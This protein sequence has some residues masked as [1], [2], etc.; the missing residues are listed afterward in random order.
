MAYLFVACFEGK[1]VSLQASPPWGPPIRKAIAFADQHC[2]VDRFI[3]DLGG[4]WPPL[5]GLA[6]VVEELGEFAEAVA[7][8][9]S[10]AQGEE[11]TDLFT[12]VSAITNQ[13]CAW[14]SP[15]QVE[16]LSAQDADLSQ[17]VQAC[18]LLGR[19]VNQFEGIK[20]PKP[21]EQVYDIRLV[22]ARICA[23][24]ERLVRELGGH[25]P[26]MVLDSLKSK[27]VRDVDRFAVSF[28][29]TTAKSLDVL[30]L[31]KSKALVDWAVDAR[32]WGEPSADELHHSGTG[33]TVPLHH[34]ER[35][36]RI[37][38]WLPL[39]A[40]VGMTT[41]SATHEE[42]LRNARE[43]LRL[44]SSVAPSVNLLGAATVSSGKLFVLAR[45]A[46]GGWNMPPETFPITL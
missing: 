20:P 16:E 2:Q 27:A 21:G 46:N 41:Q 13:Y 43:K 30:R 39:D 12:V 35:F 37:S 15:E 23:I 24:I 25:L 40:Y 19:M 45:R 3:R 33:Q 5:G 31:H 28:D 8:R 36:V 34:F 17:L 4:Y 11:L 6:R 26:S 29:P 32:L 38:Q 1:L 9:S 22:V 14:P 44:W 18:G 7:S 42:C 10:I